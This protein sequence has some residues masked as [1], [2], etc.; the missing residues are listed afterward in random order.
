MDALTTNF[1][2]RVTSNFPGM[3][4]MAMGV[5][6]GLLYYKTLYF[7]TPDVHIPMRSSPHAPIFYFFRLPA[8]N[9][10]IPA[11]STA[12]PNSY[13]QECQLNI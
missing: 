3:G 4:S 13:S 6:E 11:I 8:P 5:G 1:G 2:P 10:L 9:F 7:L 12:A